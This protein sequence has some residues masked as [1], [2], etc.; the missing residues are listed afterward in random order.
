M[1]ISYRDNAKKIIAVLLAAI[2]ILTGSMSATAYSAWETYAQEASS[3]K[4]A[5]KASKKCEVIL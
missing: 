2:M 4:S 1:K 3:V 5:Y